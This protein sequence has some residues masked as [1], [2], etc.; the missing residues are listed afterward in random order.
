VFYVLEKFIEGFKYTIIEKKD[1]D[2]R[3]FN[4]IEIKG[5]GLSKL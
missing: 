2:G 4:I 3:E 5:I 1:P